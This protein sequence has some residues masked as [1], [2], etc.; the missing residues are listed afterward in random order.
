MTQLISR[1]FPDIPYFADPYVRTILKTILFIWAVENPDIGYRQGMHELLAVILLICDRDSLERDVPPV[2]GLK[3]MHLS[4]PMS[5]LLNSFDDG[6]HSPSGAKMEDAMFMVLDRRYLEH[7]AWE[8]FAVLMQHARHWY[9]W[10]RE[11][12]E[13][14]LAESRR[15]NTKVGRRKMDQSA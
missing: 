13:G 11:T 2:S 3:N 7:D 9:E 12:V 14:S 8:L 10:R 6:R 5:P 1:S 4:V 15:Q